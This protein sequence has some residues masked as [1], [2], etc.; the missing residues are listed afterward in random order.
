[1]LDAERGWTYASR[2]DQGPIMYFTRTFGSKAETFDAAL[3]P[4]EDRIDKPIDRD[5]N[6]LMHID[7]VF[8]PECMV[9]HRVASEKRR[10]A[11]G[12]RQCIRPLVES[13]TPGH[14]GYPLALVRIM[15]TVW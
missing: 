2:I 6:D 8:L 9:R 14:D 1:M 13:L 10:M 4:S 11:V 7:Q 5:A 15:W 3:E 12:L